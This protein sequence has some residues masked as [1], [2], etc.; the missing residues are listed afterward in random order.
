MVQQDKEALYARERS[1]PEDIIKTYEYLKA[2]WKKI[3]ISSRRPRAT[4]NSIMARLTFS[5]VGPTVIR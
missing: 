2:W 5:R 3:S 1:V 4:A